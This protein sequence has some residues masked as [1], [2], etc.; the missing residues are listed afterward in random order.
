MVFLSF[1]LGLFYRSASLYHPQR[2][3][4]LHLKSIK[5]KIKEKNKSQEDRQP[6][7]DI[8]CLRSVTFRIILVSAGVSSFGL[9]TPLIYLVSLTG[10]ERG[11]HTEGAELLVWVGVSWVVGCLLWGSLCLHRSRECHVSRQYLCQ[12]CLALAALSCLAMD[13]VRQI[14]TPTL[15]LSLSLLLSLSL[16]FSL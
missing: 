13:S 15:S 4:I 9:Y 1:I 2:R 14:I 10:T 6:F 16:S 7:F 5:R 12:A 11:G 3:A 8:S